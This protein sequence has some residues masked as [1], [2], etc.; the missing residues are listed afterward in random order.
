MRFHLTTCSIISVSFFEE[1]NQ[2]IDLNQF[3]L[4]MFTNL[5]KQLNNLIH[6]V[7]AERY[8]DL[9]QENLRPH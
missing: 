2:Q 1:I 8:I 6:N 5:A 3:S 7:L 9:L 4:V